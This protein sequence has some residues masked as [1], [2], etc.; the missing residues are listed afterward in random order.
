MQEDKVIAL[1]RD[2]QPAAVSLSSAFA[3][4]GESLRKAV[5]QM[6]DVSL[7]VDVS[8]HLMHMRFRAYK[9]RQNS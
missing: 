2:N 7:E 1:M 3:A 4:L 5:G 8:G 6:D 9:H